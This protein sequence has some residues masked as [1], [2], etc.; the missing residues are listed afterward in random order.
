MDSDSHEP[1]LQA[2]RGHRQ[3]GQSMVEFA[4]ITPLFLILVLGIIDFG[5]GLRAYV[6]LTNASREGARYGVTLPTNA[7]DQTSNIAAIKARVMDYSS[8]TIASADDVTVEYPNGLAGGNSVK[9]TAHHDYEYITP[10]GG[11][12]SFLLPDPLPM[13]ASS[14]MRIE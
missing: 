12:L 9:V 10:L 1:K 13:S 5:W 7:S 2:K 3:R 11:M 8:G 4:L 14:Q 6:T